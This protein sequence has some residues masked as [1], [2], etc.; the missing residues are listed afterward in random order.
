MEG[1]GKGTHG[2]KKRKGKPQSARDA[3]RRPRTKREEEEERKKI[4]R[5]D[6]AVLLDRRE[7]VTKEKQLLREVLT[8]KAPGPSSNRG[9]EKNGEEGY[10]FL[11]EVPKAAR[12]NTKRKGPPANWGRRKGKLKVCYRDLNPVGNP[13]AAVLREGGGRGKC[14]R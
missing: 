13:G 8:E 10:T 9:K 6:I 7:R 14:Q 11:L 4:T 12:L 3:S 5:M 2:R 1:K